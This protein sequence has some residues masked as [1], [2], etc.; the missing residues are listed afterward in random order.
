MHALKNVPRYPHIAVDILT[1][2]NKH[3]A[4]HLSENV[5]FLLE[6]LPAI[7]H[8]TWNNLDPRM[9][10]TAENPGV[11]PTLNDFEVELN[12]A[13]D[14][15]DARGVPFQVER[16]P[17]CYMAR[18]AHRSTETRRIVKREERLTYFL[19][20]RGLF[21]WADWGHDKADCCAA[22]PLNEICAGLYQMDVFYSSRELFPVFVSKEKI[23]RAVLEGD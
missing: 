5:I 2:I 16:V 19:D 20:E 21:R 10:R 11:I 4:D 7:K 14:I 22:C 1:T 9:N 8:L 6:R 15:L 12:L 13:M 18:H 17:L 3:N 23:I